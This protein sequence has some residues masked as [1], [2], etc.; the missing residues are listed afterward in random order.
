MGLDIWPCQGTPY[1][2]QSL[3]NKMCSIDGPEKHPFPVMGLYKRPR[4]DQLRGF[5]ATGL[6]KTPESRNSLDFAK[7]VSRGKA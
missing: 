4:Q 6:L 3:P 7:Q 1:L 5:A 2:L